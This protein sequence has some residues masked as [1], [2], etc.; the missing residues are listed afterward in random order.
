MWTR[1]M[2]SAEFAKSVLIG[3][4]T[5]ALAACGS[6]PMSSSSSSVPVTTTSSSVPVTSTT[7]SASGYGVVQAIDVVP[8]EQAGV[9]VGTVA[10]AIVGGVLGNQVGSGRGRTA[11][12]VA[13]AAGGALAGNTIEKNAQAGQ[14]YRV[15]VRMDN[16]SVQTLTQDVAPGVQVGERVRLENGVIVERFR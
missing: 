4:T 15:A 11:A 1:K 5:L 10:G 13:G 2:K 16:G 3:A 14:V 6:Q 7:S 8:R 12:T 9:G